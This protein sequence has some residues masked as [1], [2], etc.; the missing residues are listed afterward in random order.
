MYGFRGKPRYV[1][2]VAIINTNIRRQYEMPVEADDID[3]QIFQ[4]WLLDVIPTVDK[5]YQ[6]RVELYREDWY[7]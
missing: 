7:A 3:R 4:R 5:R 6:M 1:V 2:I